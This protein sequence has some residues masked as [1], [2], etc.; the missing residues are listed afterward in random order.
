MSV[1]IEA[2]IKEVI[3][4]TGFI[5]LEEFIRLALY[6]PEH[7]YYMTRDPLGAQGDFTTAPEISQMFGEVVGSWIAD[8]WMQMGKPD[9]VTLVECGP[10]R[11]TL[12]VDIL[13]ATSQV[14][15]FHDALWVQLME[16]SPVLLQ[17]QQELL[18]G[19]NNI[20][21]IADLS[22][23]PVDKPVIIIGNEFLDAFPVQHYRRNNDKTQKAVIALERE[24]FVLDWQVVNKDCVIGEI[25]EVS[26]SQEQIIDA[27]LDKLNKATGVCLFIDYGYFSGIGDTLQ[28]LKD[29][30][31]VGL[32]DDVGNSDITAHVNFGRIKELV[33]T[34]N[35]LWHGFITQHDFLKKL[36]IE[37]RVQSLK[38]AALKSMP[39]EK[40]QEKHESIDQDLNRLIGAKGMGELFK[41]V[42]FS[43]GLDIRPAG[44]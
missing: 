42:C 10:G 35:A 8:I 9:D 23:V 18:V 44:F 19:Y 39:L 28:V 7:G 22:D 26:K 33:E 14:R 41:V 13:R 38:N 12:M 3:S 5:D 16:C 32:F 4:K 34:Q 15:G 1:E 21:W 11:G 6:D 37:Y 31:K 36:G 25:Y 40:A 17:K 20:E 27:C 2:K 29:H 24:A 30:Q 43:E